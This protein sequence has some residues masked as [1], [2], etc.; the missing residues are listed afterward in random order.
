MRCRQTVILVDHSFLIEKPIQRNPPFCLFEKTHFP[1]LT[2]IQDINNLRQAVANIGNWQGLCENLDVDEGIVDIL[3]FSNDQPVIKKSNCLKAYFDKGGATWE[4][5]ILA[6][7]KYPLKKVH[8]A[9]YIAFTYLQEPNLTKILEVL[10]SC[11]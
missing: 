6:V 2:T 8:L 4:E 7:A 9:M 5:V 3:M 10:H 1:S 11:D